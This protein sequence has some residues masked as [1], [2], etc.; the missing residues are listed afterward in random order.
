MRELFVKSGGMQIRILYAFDPTR[1]AFIILGGDKVGNDR[2]YE[3]R[4][5]I[6]EKIYA[7]HIKEIERAEN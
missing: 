7:R 5:P 2:W 4:I 6:A 3:Q 1:A